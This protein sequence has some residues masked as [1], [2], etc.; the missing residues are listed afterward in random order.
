MITE[1]TV[2]EK[3]C[4][5]CASDYH[6]EMI[7][8]PYICKKVK[9][10]K[11]IIITQDDLDSSIKSVQIAPYDLWVLLHTVYCPKQSS[12]LDSTLD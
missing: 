3:S 1:E 4:L 5:F 7:L 8:L 2:I 9:K 10:E 6:L 12:L 11:I